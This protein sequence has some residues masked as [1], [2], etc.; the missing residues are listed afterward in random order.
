[1]KLLAVAMI[2]NEA[3]ILPSFLRH[4]L[5][6]FDGGYL[7]DHRSTDGSSDLLKLFCSQYPQWNYTYLNFPGFFQSEV[8]KFFLT[9]A[10]N[11]TV[12][13]VVLLDAD[14]FIVGP[15]NQFEERFAGVG[16]DHVGLIKWRNCIPASFDDPVELPSPLWIS[17]KQAPFGKVVITRAFFE[18]AKSDFTLFPGNHWIRLGDGSRAPMREFAE[19]YHLPLRSKRQTVLKGITKVLGYLARG[20]DDRDAGTHNFEL[21]DLAAAGRL[22]DDELVSFVNSYGLRA[23]QRPAITCQTLAAAGFVMEKPNVALSDELKPDLGAD[24][25]SQDSTLLHDIT[26]ILA[27]WGLDDPGP[28]FVLENG[29]LSASSNSQPRFLGTRAQ[30]QNSLLRD[31]NT[32]LGNQNAFL[33]NENI[34]VRN[35]NTVVKTENTV[36]SKRNAV[37]EQELLTVFGLLKEVQKDIAQLKASRSWRLTRPLRQLMDLWRGT[38]HHS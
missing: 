14:E 23:E 1:M 28:P 32:F 37:L 38:P 29:H 8:C 24:P 16:L 17:R 11:N 15:R 35:E 21:V 34:A 10:F 4:I 20:V 3:D 33:T 36:L 25:S 27:G 13:A 9:E 2:R 19:L 7:L 31:Q 12:D 18:R 5:A 26:A 6:F 22:T 30:K